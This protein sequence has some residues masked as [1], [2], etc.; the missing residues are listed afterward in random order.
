[1]YLWNKHFYV[2]ILSFLLAILLTSC[3]KSES[4]APIEIHWGKDTC[5]HCRMIIKDQHFG[6]Q[7]RGGPENKVYLFNELGSAM[8]WLDKQP[9]SNNNT[10]K[11][12]VI[13]YN[14][15]YWLDARFANYLP[16]QPTPMNYGFSAIKSPMKGSV[17]FETARRRLMAKKQG[18]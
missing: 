2:S 1:M 17:N 6:A 3:G 18:R 16:E 9:W 10:T 4:E 8:M 14:T 15:G 13:D 7:I 5:E 11:I 12:W